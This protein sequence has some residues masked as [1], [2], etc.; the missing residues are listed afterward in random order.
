MFCLPVPRP[1]VVGGIANLQKRFRDARVSHN[2]ALRGVAKNRK[3][4]MH[5]L[6]GSTRFD[7]TSGEISAGIERN[8]VTHSRYVTHLDS[9]IAVDRQMN[10][11]ERP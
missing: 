5:T 8:P 10:R 7:Y 2:R 4:L 11:G 6:G 3:F 9:K 1:F